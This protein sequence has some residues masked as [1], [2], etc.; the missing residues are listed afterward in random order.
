MNT[1]STSSSGLLPSNTIANL[2]EELKSITTRSGLVLDGPSVPMPHPFIN[3]EEDE[4]VEETLTDPELTEFTIN[5]PPPL[6]LKALL[7]NKEK[8]LELANTSLNENCSSV[9]LKKLPEKLG[10][11]RK[12]LIPCGFSE[13]KCKALA[14]IGSSIN[15]MPLLVWKKLDMSL[16]KFTFLAD[17]VIVDYESDPRV[18][19]ILV[20]P[21][22]RTD[23]ALINVH[24]EEMILRDGDERL[25]LNI[26]HDTSSYSNQP[27]KELINMINVYNDSYEDYLEDL[28]A[29]NHL[30][31]NPTFS[32][33]TDLTSSEII[34][35]LSGNPTSSSPDHLIE[36]FAN[37][38]ALITF[39]LGNDDLPFD[40]ESDLRELEYLRNHDPIK[41][42]ASILE[43][44]VDE[45]YLADPNN[46]LFDTIPEMI[47]ILLFMN[48]LSTKKF[49]GPK[50]YY[51][52]HPKMRK[53]FSTPGFL[54][55]KEFILLFSRNYLIGALKL[56]KSLKFLK[57]DEDFS[58]LLWRGHPYFG[59]FVSPFLSPM[60]NLIR[61]S[62]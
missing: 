52:F 27:H 12:F 21:F 8:I 42:M 15:L 44:S 38:L 32:S 50:L 29:T 40:I 30:S 7:S 58:L 48:F 43:D 3:S 1:A 54:L 34:N 20:R 2:K 41:E 25:T 31:G 19:L 49:P 51:H 36:E 35:P 39:Q 16:L 13:L 9:I 47:L 56:S 6:M 28:F 17:F 10:V 11:P 57:P 33:H 18:P 53:K 14:D 4:C 60:N 46:N 45:C 37:E 61:G 55:L 24:G 23:R 26:R 62:G 59:C 5:V 22:L